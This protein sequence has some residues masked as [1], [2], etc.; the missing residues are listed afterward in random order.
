MAQSKRSKSPP[1]KPAATKR[2][3]AGRFAAGGPGG[4]GR[5]KGSTA[6]R[7]PTTDLLELSRGVDR[8]N[9]YFAAMILRDAHQYESIDDQ[10]AQISADF[11]PAIAAKVQHLAYASQLA[12]RILLKR[13]QQE[14]AE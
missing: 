10:L 5:P 3:A 6:V 7:I 12:E 4:P 13:L 2:D 8:N 9:L 11:S 14:A 1:T